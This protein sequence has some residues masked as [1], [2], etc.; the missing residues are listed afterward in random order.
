MLTPGYPSTPSSAASR[1]SPFPGAEGSLIIRRRTRDKERKSTH[2]RM[3]ERQEQEPV[4]L[5][6]RAV[7]PQG[8]LLRL[9]GLSL[10][11]PRTAG[12]PLPKR[13][14]KD[15][16]PVAGPVHR[17]LQGR[18]VMAKPRFVYGP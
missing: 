16:G 15:L 2:E 1:R 3:Q 9:P 11:E 18:G 5:H 12:L 6:L 17:D 8:R 13:G 7:Q 4:Q 10:A 14:R